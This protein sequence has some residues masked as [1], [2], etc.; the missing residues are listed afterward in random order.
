MS[1]FVDTG[2]FVAFHNTR[3]TNHNRA[4]ELLRSIVDGELGTAYT[5]EYVFDEA[6]TAALVRTR[7][8]ENAL[9]VGRM[10]LGELTAPFL[11][12]LR[13]DDEAFK[14]AWRLFPQYA[15]RGLSF[16]DCSSIT[17]MRTAG[18]ESIVSF[19][20]DFDGIVSRIS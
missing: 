11:A 3:D 6:V 10:I 17:L 15:G 13:L 9:A 12:I 1:V 19:D 7:R 2:V 18:I 5:S 16:T 14:E 20:A 4:L 8:P